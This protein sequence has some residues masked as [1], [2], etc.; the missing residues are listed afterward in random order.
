MGAVG[1]LPIPVAGSIVGA[2]I[3]GAAGAF[4]GAWLGEMWKHGRPDIS[5]NVGWGALIGRLLGTAGKLI[6]G[7][8]MLVSLAIHA[9]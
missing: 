1:G 3:G 7:A 6:V 9:L 5:V 2:L 4:T 8:V